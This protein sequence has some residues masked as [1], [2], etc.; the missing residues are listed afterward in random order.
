MMRTILRGVLCLSLILTPISALALFDKKTPDEER[1]ELQEARTEAMKK[2]YQEKPS[3]ESEIRNAR[4]YA[5]FSNFGLN[6]GFVSTQRGGGI[7]RD[8]RTGKDTYMRMF[9]GGGGWGLGVKNFAAIL[10]FENDEALS[11]F[12]TSG[13]DFS[14]Q[15]DANAES[16]SEGDGAETAMTAMPGTKIYQL[17]ES[18]VALQA[19]V[20]GT[21]FWVDEDLN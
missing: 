15:A 21:K 1:K 3:A 14:A 17:T 19:T 16:G 6:L 5:V 20:Q 18:G 13:W 7:L 2:L 11:Q 10:I 8:N 4:G 12:E 9:S